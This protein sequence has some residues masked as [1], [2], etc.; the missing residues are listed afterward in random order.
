MVLGGKNIQSWL[1]AAIMISEQPT[2][3]CCYSNMHPTILLVSKGFQP[4][5]DPYDGIIKLENT[6]NP[7]CLT[8]G[9][10]FSAP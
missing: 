1:R 8:A 10:M 6:N 7:L 2:I 5:S 9:L 3:G 4:S